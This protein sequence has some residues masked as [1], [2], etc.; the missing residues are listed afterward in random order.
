MNCSSIHSSVLLS[1]LCIF[2]AAAPVGS[3]NKFFFQKKI[4][5]YARYILRSDV[6]VSLLCSEDHSLLLNLL[7]DCQWLSHLS[8][9]SNKFGGIDLIHD[10]WRNFILCKMWTESSYFHLWPW[11]RRC[12]CHWLMDFPVQRCLT[13]QSIRTFTDYHELQLLCFRRISIFRNKIFI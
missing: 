2:F 4:R 1:L 9:T 7:A 8:F 6:V 11:L 3:M 10:M 12:Y 13:F 5:L